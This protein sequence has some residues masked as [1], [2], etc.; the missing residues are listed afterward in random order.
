MHNGIWQRGQ[1]AFELGPVVGLKAD[2]LSLRCFFYTMKTKQRTFLL[3]FITMISLSLVGYFTYDFLITSSKRKV[4]EEIKKEVSRYK[5]AWDSIAKVNDYK[6]DTIR[7]K[8]RAKR[9][10]EGLPAYEYKIKGKLEW[11]GETDMFNGISVYGECN[12]D[13]NKIRGKGYVFLLWGKYKAISVDL[14]RTIKGGYM[15][16]G[17]GAMYNL[18]LE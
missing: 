7:N 2:K 11:S 16:F 9:A 8:Y 10:N 4:D 18:E 14:I 15:G 12:L 17:D 1:G 13:E 3:A 6:A 5:I